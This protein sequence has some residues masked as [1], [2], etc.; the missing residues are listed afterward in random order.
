[1]F[2]FNIFNSQTTKTHDFR[3]LERNVDYFVDFT[4]AGN[5]AIVTATLGVK[6]GDKIVLSDR[7]QTEMVY[8]AEDL[9]TYW[10]DDLIQTI[11]LKKIP[12]FSD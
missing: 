12:E 2:F 11:L 7:K 8:R 9:K 1:M 5:S 6:R 3:Q 10:N 4:D